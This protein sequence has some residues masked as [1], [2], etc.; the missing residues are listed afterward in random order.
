MPVF[1]FFGDI[2]L[3]AVSKACFYIETTYYPIPIAFDMLA[4]DVQLYYM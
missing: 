4:H 3:L 1:Y 2:A